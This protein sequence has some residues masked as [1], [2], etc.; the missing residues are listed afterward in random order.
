MNT[1]KR[2]KNTSLNV[3]SNLFLYIVSSL[4]SFVVR[5]VFIRKLSVDLLGLDGVLLNIVTMLSIV[6]SGFSS[7]VCFKLYKPLAENDT[8][9][10]SSYMSFYKKIYNCIGIIVLV[11]GLILS[12]FLN[13]IVGDYSYKYLYTVYFIYIFNV[14]FWYFVSYKE[15][16]LFADQ[17][18]YKV[19]KYNLLFKTLIYL[20]QF[21]AIIIFK[22]YIIYVI[23]YVLF[24][25]L[26]RIINNIYI[27]KNYKEVDF[28]S[29]EQLDKKDIKDI[30]QNVFNIFFFKIG[31]YALNC[32]D[33]III[34]ALINLGAVGVYTNYMSITAML[35]SIIK[36]IFDGVTSS[37]GDLSVMNNI[38]AEK[39][40]FDIMNFIC[41]FITGYITLCLVNSF[42]VFIDIWLGKN[43]LLELSSVILICLNFYLMC[44]QIPLDTVKEAKGFYSKDKFYPI[45]L[46]VLNIILSII[47]GKFFGLNGI[48][49][50]T[51]ISYMLTITWNKP[52]VLYK[53]IFKEN[54]F[55]YYKDKII[56]FITLVFIIFISGYLI[57]Y[58]RV[59][60]KLFY[61]ILINV[62]NTIIYVI[63][64]TIFFFRKKEYQFILDILKGSFRKK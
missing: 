13:R 33:G 36:K 49:G 45:I 5:T 17:K 3:S 19:F 64:T 22:N 28:N 25:S 9:K 11:L 48:V 30:K 2:M 40:V 4:L 52:Y 58:I 38:K 12:I 27:A 10:V 21:L 61:F 20:F 32:T 37:F 50:A 35:K 14:V 42:N 23:C 55:K 57:K 24:L 43:Y 46:A 31:D 18:G 54:V 62:L 59:D 63:I 16:L 56:Y 39:N 47:L 7:A 26:N 15:V 53:Y 34:S 60:N 6:E 29:K 8:K 51:S 44:N 41:F 1:T